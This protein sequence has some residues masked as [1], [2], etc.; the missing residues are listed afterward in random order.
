MLEIIHALESN[1]ENVCN[2]VNRKYFATE[3][4]SLKKEQKFTRIDPKSVPGATLYAITNLLCL[5]KI[6]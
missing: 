5:V 3:N 4:T 6:A 1:P 2:I